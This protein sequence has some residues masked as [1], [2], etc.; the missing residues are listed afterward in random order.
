MTPTRSVPVL[1][2]PPSRIEQRRKEAERENTFFLWSP[3]QSFS[4]IGQALFVYAEI[5]EGGNP[6]LGEKGLFFPE[7]CRVFVSRSPR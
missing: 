6:D 3:T 5:R 7:P 1:G 4:P 2:L